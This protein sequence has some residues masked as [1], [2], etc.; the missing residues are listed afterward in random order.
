[1]ENFSNDSRE[2]FFEH[3]LP[4][5]VE[6]FDQVIITP[7]YKGNAQLTFIHPKIS[8]RQ[9]DAFA[10]CNRVKVFLQNFGL[11]T[12]VYFSEFFR[13][14]HKLHY[15]THFPSLLNTLILRTASAEALL[16]EVKKSTSSTIFYSYW[17]SQFAFIL[18]LMKKMDPSINAVSRAH[19]SDYNE[20]QTNSILP[21]RYFQLRALNAIVP[22]SQFA[23]NYLATKFHVDQKKIKVNRLGLKEETRL[24]PIDKAVFHLVSCSNVIP[25][26]RVHVIPAL[27]KHM[28]D[29]VQW[30]HFGAGPEMERVKEACKDLPSNVSYTLHGY[31]PN[32]D[33][34]KYISETPISFFIN[35]SEFEGI[36]VTMMEAS[37]FG[38]PLIGS[39]VCGIPELVPSIALPVEIQPEIAYDLIQSEHRHGKIYSETYRREIQDRFN[40]TFSAK[41]NFT[42]LSNFL[43]SLN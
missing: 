32:R 41:K 33:F 22:V 31:V 9:F 15:I 17:F 27:L 8:I 36:P 21:F 3:E 24:A 1:V 6:R 23:A 42:E 19:G 16:Q 4:F 38:I 40:S 34:I 7:L 28:K 18:S 14:H 43:Y 13:T 25:L 30:D 11:I 26:K 20:A 5:H 12:A 35:V 2:E 37:S 10:P 29:N 39:N